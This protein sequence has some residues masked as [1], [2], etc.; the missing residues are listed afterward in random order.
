MRARLRA[1]EAVGL[2][3]AVTSAHAAPGKPPA[4]DSL[5]AKER[6]FQARLMEVYA[7][8]LEHPTPQAGKLVDEL[9]RQGLRDNAL[10]FYVSRDNGARPRACRGPRSPSSNAQNGIAAGGS[11]TWRAGTRLRREGRLDALGGPKLDA[12]YHAAWASG[13]QDAFR[14]PSWSQAISAARARRWPCPG[15][16]RIRPDA[17]V[18]NQFHHVNDIAPTIYEMA[19]VTPRRMPST[20]HRSGSTGRRQPRCYTQRC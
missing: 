13:R 4:W 5:D 15:L 10:I 18:R 2:D 8:F 9:E 1:P 7:G 12:M 16:K 6:K 11:S 3:S 14:A 17:T 20:W 19:G